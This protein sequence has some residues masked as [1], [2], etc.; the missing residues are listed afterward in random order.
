MIRASIS[1]FSTYRSELPEEIAQLVRH[2]FD[3]IAL[4]RTKLSDIG[5]GEARTLLDTAG[6]RASSLL[7]GGGFTGGDGRSFRESLDDV[8]EGIATAVE[9]G[10]G[11]LVLH[12]GCRGGH[13]IGHARRLLAEAMHELGP[14]AAGEGVTLAIK[15]LHP[16]TS[17]DCSFL[18]GLEETFDFVD[19]LDEPAV[20]LA[21]DLWQFADEPGFIESLRRMLSRVAVVQA[22]DRFGPPSPESERLPPGQGVLPLQRIIRELV[23]QGYRGD[24]EFDCVGEA[25]EAMGVEPLLES[26]DASFSQWLGQPQVAAARR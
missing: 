16:A 25:V 6:I 14:A 5:P 9:V 23:R 19:A 13:T 11:V 1:E 8:R 24:V 10:A 21:V 3:S 20:M 22:A 4:W 12:A 26:L 18:G 17:S 15:P 2:G 7:W